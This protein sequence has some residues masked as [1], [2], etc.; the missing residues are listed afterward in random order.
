MGYSEPNAG[1]TPPRSRSIAIRIVAFTALVMFLIAIASANGQTSLDDDPLPLLRVIA[2]PEQLVQELAKLKPGALVKLPRDEFEARVRKAAAANAQV[3]ATAR[4]VSAH[5]QAEL[6]GESLVQG[7]GEWAVHNPGPGAASLPLAPLNLALSR[8]A[9]EDGRPAIVGDF[10]GKGLAAWVEATGLASLFFDWSC[11]G[12]QSPQG[13]TFDLH[14]PA[15]PQTTIELRLPSDSWPAIPPRAGL[16]TGPHDAGAAGKRLWKLQLAGKTQVELTIRTVPA[17]PVPLFVQSEAQQSVAPDRVAAD[18][19]FQVE[20]PHGAVRELT[21][22]GDGTLEPY[23]V[24]ARSA[25]LT[26][27]WERPADKGVAAP[28]TLVVEFHEP[29][30]G[31]IAGLRVRCLAPRPAP[32]ALWVS[33]GMRL[34]QAVCRAETLKLQLHPDVQLGRWFGGDFHPIGTATE[35]DGSLTLTLVNAR[36]AVNAPPARPRCQLVTSAAEF[37]TVQQTRLHIEPGASTLESEITYLVSRGELHQLAVKLPSVPGPYRVVSVDVEPKGVLRSWT[38]A[39]PLLA[40]E[41]ERAITPRTEARL[42]VRLGAPLKAKTAAFTIDL[43]DV[44]PQGAVARDGR[45]TIELDPLYHAQLLQPSVAPVPPSRNAP[46]AARGEAA[47]TFAYH[48]QTLAGKLRLFTRQPRLHVHSR[49]EAVLGQGAGQWHADVQ[50]E[51]LLGRPSFVDVYL[52]APLQAP[53]AVAV[54]GQA[55]RVQRLERLPVQ[56]VLPQLLRLGAASAVAQAVLHL[57]LPRGELWRIHFVAPLTQT[58]RLSVR[59][60]LRPLLL[61][62]AGDHLPLLLPG[63]SAWSA[64]GGIGVAARHQ[65]DTATAWDVPVLFLP[66]ARQ[67]EGEIVVRAGGQRIEGVRG[68]G[69]E[70]SAAPLASAALADGASLPLRLQGAASAWPRLELLTRRATARSADGAVCESSELTTC[71]QADGTLSHL[72]RVRLRNWHE[73]RF[74][75]VVPAAVEGLAARIDGGWVDRLE[76]EATAEGTRFVLPVNTAAATQQVE[77]L[78]A[79]TTAAGALL[80]RFVHAPAPLLPREPLVQRRYCRLPAAWLPLDRDRWRLRGEPDGLRAQHALNALPDRVWRVGQGLLPDAVNA[81]AALE[82]Q[83]DDLRKAEN[84][85]RLKLGARA[86]LGE[87]IERLAAALPGAMPVVVDVEGLRAAGRDPTTVLPANRAGDP[88]WQSVDVVPIACPSGV[89]LTTQRRLDQW[90]PQTRDADLGALLDPAVTEAALHGLDHAGCFASV[91]Q[92]RGLVPQPVAAPVSRD[93]GLAF[94]MFAPAPAVGWLEWEPLPGLPPEPTLALMHEP[95]GRRLGYLLASLWFIAAAWLGWRLGPAAFLRMHLVAATAL[96]LAVLTLPGPLRDGVA[97]PLLLAEALAFAI[98]FTVRSWPGRAAPRLSRSTMIRVSGAAIVLAVAATALPLSAQAPARPEPHV[99]FLVRGAEPGQEFA[100]AAPALLRKLD[101]MAGQRSARPAGATVVAAQYQGTLQGDIADFEARFE[102]HHFADKSTFVLP[103]TGVQLQPGVFLDGA[104]VF[105]VAHKGGYALPVR[106]KG[107]H[108]LTL[109]FRLRPALVNDLHELR[110]GVPRA[111]QCQL[112]LTTTMPARG[113]HLVGGPG[114]TRMQFDNKGLATLSTQLGHEGLVQLRW[115]AAVKPAQ[116]GTAIEVREAYYWDLRPQTLGLTAGVQFTIAKGSVSQLHFAL[117]DGLDV[118]QVELAGRTATPPVLPAPVL[119]QWHV[120]GAGATRQLVID[121]AQPVGNTVT[122]LVGMVPRLALTPGQWVLRLPAPLGATSTAGILAYRLEGMDAVASPQNLSIGTIVTPELLAEPWAGLAV[123]D[124]STVTKLVKFSRI[125]RS[126]ALVLTVQP[127][128]P[129]AQLDLKWR[130]APRYADLTAR[131]NLAS[132]AEDLTLVEL[133]LPPRFKLVRIGGEVGGAHLHHWTRQDRLVQLWL[134]Q[135]RKQ[136]NLEVHGWV[137]HGKDAKTGPASTF[138]LAP[139]RVVQTRSSISTIALEP[140]PGLA[141][142]PERLIHL[143]VTGMDDVLR[144]R[145]DGGDYAATFALRTVAAPATGRAFTLLERHGGVVEM[146]TALHLRPRPGELRIVASGSYGAD[147]RLESPAPVLRKGYQQQGTEHIWTVQIPPGLPQTITFTLRGRFTVDRPMQTWT[148]PTVKL[149]RV[150]LTDH[151]LGLA[152]VEPADPHAIAPDAA[153]PPPQTPAYP[154]PPHELT[155][156]MQIGKLAQA[157]APFIFRVPAAAP[158][159]QVLFAQHE[160]FWAGASWSHRLRLLAFAAGQGEL[161]VRL[162]N[163]AR[164]RAVLVDGRVM[165]PDTDDL[166]IPL[167]D[168]PGPRWIDVCWTYDRGERL[169]A[170]RLARPAVEGLAVGAIPCCFWLPAGYELPSIPARTD[171]GSADRLLRQ[172][173]ARMQL[174]RLWSQTRPPIEQLRREQQAFHGDIADA[175]AAIQ[176]LARLAAV[177]TTALASRSRQLVK[178]NARLAA[179]GKYA[180]PAATPNAAPRDGLAVAEDGVPLDWPTGG[181][182]A[183]IPAAHRDEVFEHTGVELTILAAIGLLL[184]TVLRR[185]VA[186][187]HLLWPETLAALAAVGVALGGWTPLA[188]GMLALAVALRVVWLI[189]F[190]QRA[191]PGWFAAAPEPTSG[192]NGPIPSP[193]AA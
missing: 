101:E 2:T 6:S 124:P 160:T 25:D 22:D 144:L 11:R 34:R 93:I 130:V 47:Y 171:A 109:R 28:G 8:A 82:A 173:E 42:R 135:P 177:D 20:V 165:T 46:A 119:R 48:D 4:V 1:A 83:R 155:P 181:A 33:P 61:S 122:L 117:P 159:A 19:N 53:W 120:T 97:L 32:P 12:T 111:G 5:Y 183:L 99:V 16:L 129:A 54:D 134:Q 81:S 108:Q 87:A 125:S 45:F 112:E 110:F 185:G 100:L 21:F 80:A 156:G 182:L 38:S 92:W 89:L 17:V 116:A 60:A 139:L 69:I 121:L 51:P 148:L 166:A 176:Q 154:M 79:S 180:T 136:I 170:P 184:I 151:W 192:D 118:R 128:R 84:H 7:H 178:E 64:L 66:G 70:A 63:A 175:N 13:L 95:T 23:E 40:I 133:E 76:A 29:Q 75:V 44:V 90:Q 188:V 18:F 150:T 189:V 35:P 164:C 143:A 43:P 56:E 88:F 98:A 187:F 137:E 67:Q 123:R 103:L 52:S 104:P 114:E 59:G 36:A 153:G 145:S 55:T 146:S 39:G 3:R 152:G 168:V 126:A 26:W 162:P 147:L 77:L 14:V 102:L 37:A 174:C 113:L 186:L 161:R 105:P 49:Q 57:E 132:N 127:A 24:T 58:T 158:S 73:P 190:V 9:W 94:A 167:G 10:E 142:A 71:M 30:Q 131:I 157:A 141:L 163:G 68:Q 31:R 169:A 72:L 193:P 172:A 85:V 91:G 78:Y 27:R 41:L 50:I 149:D 191:I 107:M 115:P 140:Q 179:E 65:A 62:L 74:T 138:E 96:V 86:T 106:G 15:C